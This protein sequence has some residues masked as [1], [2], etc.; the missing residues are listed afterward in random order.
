MVGIASWPTVATSLCLMTHS[1]FVQM[2]STPVLPHWVTWSSRLVRF[3]RRCITLSRSVIP[4]PSYYLY[5][6]LLLLLFLHPKNHKNKAVNESMVGLPV[7]PRWY[8]VRY[9]VYYGMSSWSARQ[10]SNF[11][12]SLVR[13]CMHPWPIIMWWLP[14]ESGSC[15]WCGVVP[16]SVR[17]L[18]TSLPTSLTGSL[19]RVWIV[20][21][22][23]WRRSFSLPCS[24]SWPRYPRM[25]GVDRY[26]MSSV[27]PW[28]WSCNNWP[29]P[30][31][32]VRRRWGWCYRHWWS[33]G[34]CTVY[35]ERA[36]TPRK[37]LSSSF[38]LS[39]T[40]YCCYSHRFINSGVT[41][42]CVWCV[43]QIVY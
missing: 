18:P 2:R 11:I 10:R 28:W 25:Y 15:Y 14:H 12:R 17:P 40:T 3:S 41:W 19:M 22:S 8:V 29:T 35:V 34:S 43:R 39:C 21:E 36:P 24:H 6:L 42:R 26:S 20:D 31:T 38:R 7:V 16:T 30:P 27:V 23:N 4:S 5:L 1:M 9:W 37:I 33:C 13:H 32:S